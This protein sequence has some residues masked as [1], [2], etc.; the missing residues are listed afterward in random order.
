MLADVAFRSFSVAIAFPFGSFMFV[1]AVYHIGELF[2]PT[3]HNFTIRIRLSV[4]RVPAIRPYFGN[5]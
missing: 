3:L 2:P 1:H 4:L 5:E